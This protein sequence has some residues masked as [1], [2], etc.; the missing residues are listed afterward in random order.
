MIETLILIITAIGIGLYQYTNKPTQYE[1]N[2][3]DG[4]NTEVVLQKNSSYSCPV[5]CETD[6]IHIAVTCDESCTINHQNY[7]LH[8]VTEIDEGFATFC[9]KKIIAMNKISTKKKL[10]DIV[11]AS[12]SE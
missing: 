2:M 12:K 7:H 9:S 6:H 8:N 1:L 3:E 5:Y 10:P 4:T 11:S